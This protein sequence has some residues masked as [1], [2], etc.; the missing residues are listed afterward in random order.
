MADKNGQELY[1]RLEH[2]GRRTAWTFRAGH[3]IVEFGFDSHR[4]MTDASAIRLECLTYHAGRFN[5]RLVIMDR[6]FMVISIDRVQDAVVPSPK[7]TH[8]GVCNPEGYEVINVSVLARKNDDASLSPVRVTAN[9]KHVER[10]YGGNGSD[11]WLAYN[12]SNLSVLVEEAEIDAEL[13]EGENP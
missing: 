1:V 3:G 4:P 6:E 9:G 8:T 11:I 7:V 2:N 12:D 10:Q 5:T 13:L